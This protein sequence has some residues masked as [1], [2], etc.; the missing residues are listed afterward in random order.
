MTNQKSNT[1]SM[2][3]RQKDS[4]L[5]EGI[6]LEEIKTRKIA[7]YKKKQVKDPLYK[8]LQGICNIYLFYGIY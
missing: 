1:D 6:F 5:N 3:Y 8:L 4:C 2:H 7:Y